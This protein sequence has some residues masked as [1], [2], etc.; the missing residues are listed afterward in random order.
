MIPIAKRQEGK[1]VSKDPMSASPVILAPNA[2]VTEDTLL[3]EERE[4]VTKASKPV[5]K[6][7]NGASVTVG[8]LQS[9]KFAT[10]RTTTVTEKSM[11]V[12]AV[13]Q[14]TNE[15]ATVAL[16]KQQEKVLVNQVNKPAAA[17]DNGPAQNV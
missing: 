15:V 3:S 5:V 7:S 14:E 8:A 17:Q 13:T 4:S 10:K 12:A 1:S 9:A 6:T 16:P 2:N 11:K